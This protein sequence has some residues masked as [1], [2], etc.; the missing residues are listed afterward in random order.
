[1]EDMRIGVNDIIRRCPVVAKNNFTLKPIIIKSGQLGNPYKTS[2][3]KIIIS[4]CIDVNDQHCPQF[5]KKH[6]QGCILNIA[7]LSMTAK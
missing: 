4:T 3:K 7:S 6:P 2:A 1:M 5:L